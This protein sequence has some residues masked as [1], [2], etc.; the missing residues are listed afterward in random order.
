MF[1]I[2]RVPGKT[3]SGERLSLASACE[4]LDFQSARAVVGSLSFHWIEPAAGDPFLIV[5]GVNG[6]FVKVT[7]D[8]DADAP[9]VCAPA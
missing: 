1:D 3:V 5:Q 6:E 4:Y 9:M 8:A 7:V 2:K